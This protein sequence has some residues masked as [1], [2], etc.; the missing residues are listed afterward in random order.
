MWADYLEPTDAQVLARYEDPHLGAW[1]AVTTHPHG[2]GRITVVGTVPSQGLARA[3]FSWAVPRPLAGWDL[4]LDVRVS[5]ST[6]SDGR[7]LHVLHH[8][9]WGDA[10]L[11]APGKLDDVLDPS[12]HLD[13]GAAVE[14]GPWDV[15]VLVGP[16]PTAES[17]QPS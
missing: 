15:R 8:W 6:T 1:A 4:P 10:S 14:L 12:A 17:D 3:L 7:R 2:A 13:P 5:T 11:T 16:A 9:G